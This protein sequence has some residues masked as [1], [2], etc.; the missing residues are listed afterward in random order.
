MHLHHSHIPGPLRQ[1]QPLPLPT[2]IVHDW[3]SDH[4]GP[5]P[6]AMRDPDGLGCQAWQA[7]SL[8][9]RQSRQWGRKPPSTGIYKIPKVRAGWGRGVLV[10]PSLT[11]CFCNCCLQFK[12]FI[13]R[14]VVVVYVAGGLCKNRIMTPYWRIHDLHCGA[15]FFWGGPKSQGAQTALN[16]SHEFCSHAIWHCHQ[17]SDAPP[18]KAPEA[19]A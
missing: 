16:L 13:F 3:E 17:G 10:V 14:F 11:N 15:F 6:T 1:R 5:P 4:L 2:Q 8:I 18:S 9:T 12:F 19:R 7:W